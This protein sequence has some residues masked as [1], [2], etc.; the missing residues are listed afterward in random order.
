MNFFVINFP[1]NWLDTREKMAD[2]NLNLP[3]WYKNLDYEYLLNICVV[4]QGD[5]GTQYTQVILQ[6]IFQFMDVLK[7]ILYLLTSS[8]PYSGTIIIPSFKLVKTVIMFIFHL[9]T[10]SAFVKK[11]ERTYLKGKST[12]WRSKVHYL[13]MYMCKRYLL[14]HSSKILEFLLDQN[15]QKNASKSAVSYITRKFHAHEL[16]QILNNVPKLFIKHNLW[17]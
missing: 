4:G 13:Y 17:N 8:C 1:A 12:N 15:F 3:I 5:P 2:L 16:W 6:N 10:I 11:L 7:I 14:L 9:S